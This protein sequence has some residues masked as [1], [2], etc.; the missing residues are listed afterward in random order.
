MRSIKGFLRFRERGFRSLRGARA[1]F[2]LPPVVAKNRKKHKNVHETGRRGSKTDKTRGKRT[3]FLRYG[4]EWQPFRSNQIFL[5]FLF[6]YAFGMFGVTCGI[7]STP[8]TQRTQYLTHPNF[9]KNKNLHEMGRRGSKINNSG[10]I[11]HQFFG[12]ELMVT[13]ISLKTM[14]FVDFQKFLFFDIWKNFCPLVTEGAL[15]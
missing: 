5:Y 13:A 6:V 11:P 14:I 8:N 7:L 4:P 2:P 15:N 9:Q 12:P 3:D 10:F 1:V